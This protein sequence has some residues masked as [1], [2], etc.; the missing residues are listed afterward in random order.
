M[1]AP[2]NFIRKKPRSTSYEYGYIKINNP[3]PNEVREHIVLGEA[4]TS[5]EALMNN[6]MALTGKSRIGIHGSPYREMGT[7]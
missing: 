3:G 1:T 6:A 5:D 7:L 4:L 2:C